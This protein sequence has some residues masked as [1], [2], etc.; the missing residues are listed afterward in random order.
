MKCGAAR[1]CHLRGSALGNSAQ[2][3]TAA[4]RT[5]TS[6]SEDGGVRD[7]EDGAS[8]AQTM[9]T[10]TD[11]G[12]CMTGSVQNAFLL[13]AFDVEGRCTTDLGLDQEGAM[14]ILQGNFKE[15]HQQKY[16]ICRKRDVACA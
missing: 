3:K 10:T 13:H 2:L 4:T 9:R 6:T 7:V 1:L 15:V 11:D 16:G 12:E 8:D 14:G 5:R